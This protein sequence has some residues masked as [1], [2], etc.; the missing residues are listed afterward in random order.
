MVIIF[1]QVEGCEE[2]DL[3]ASVHGVVLMLLAH[4]RQTV[5]STDDEQSGEPIY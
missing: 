2:S 1:L 3:M 4:L 5:S